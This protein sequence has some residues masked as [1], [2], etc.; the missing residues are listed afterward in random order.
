MRAK[1]FLKEEDYAAFERI[2]DEAFLRVPLRVLGY[3]V[4]PDHWHMVVW[5]RDGL[6]HE[7]SDFL[8]WLTVTHAQPWHAHYDSSGSGHLYQG[9]YKSLPVESDEH[10]YTVLRYVERNPLRANLVERR[11]TGDGRVSVA[12]PREMTRSAICWPPGR[13]LDRRTGPRGSTEPRA[14]R[15]WKRFAAAC[16]ADSP[17]AAS[18]DANGSSRLWV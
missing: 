5:P 15:S 13:S 14:R 1:L 12:T 2:L 17:T 16:S 7:V 8:R 6:D 3:C 4:M 10:L 11:K 18:Y 9:R